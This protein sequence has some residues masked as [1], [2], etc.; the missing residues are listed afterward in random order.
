VTVQ[1]ITCCQGSCLMR[2][3][4]IPRLECF[5]CIVVPAT[6]C[7]RAGERGPSAGKEW[8]WLRDNPRLD[9][10]HLLPDISHNST[11]TATI[12]SSSSNSQLFHGSWQSGGSSRPWR[13]C[14]G[15]WWEEGWRLGAVCL[16]SWPAH[17]E[18]LR[19]LAVDPW[20][21]LLVTAGELIGTGRD[22][23]RLLLTLHVCLLAEGIS[24]GV[25]RCKP[26]WWALI[27]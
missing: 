3:V 1:G 16:H 7:V 13:V 9:P 17:K 27:V 12:S 11:A 6:M 25:P 23:G 10:S 15:M 2:L 14:G 19:A 21:R 5:V 4:C 18:R 22:P 20:E 24:L 26:R 8:F